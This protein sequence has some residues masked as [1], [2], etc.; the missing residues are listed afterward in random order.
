[1][2]D[3]LK[4]HK[5]RAT[6]IGVGFAFLLFVGGGIYLQDKNMQGNQTVKEASPKTVKLKVS[7]QTEGQKNTQSPA[8][9]SAFFLR[10][11]A[12]ELLAELAEMENL[13]KDVV[14]SKF[15]YLRV[16]WPAF[17]FTLEQDEAG[18]TTMLLDVSEDGFGVQIQS[19]VDVGAFP[20]LLE[21]TTGEKM[22]L[23]G[24]ILAVDPNGTGTI[25]I[26][27][28]H[29]SFGDEPPL[30]LPEPKTEN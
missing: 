21:L 3:F 8:T 19:E 20:Q 23:G 13:N 22:W 11:S 29:I 15:S 10:P 14:N 17:F 5:E 26:K 4:K 27:T 9:T 28:E 25:Y 6:L 7:P 16:L 24:E 30:T 12:D 18:Q 2:L 1:V